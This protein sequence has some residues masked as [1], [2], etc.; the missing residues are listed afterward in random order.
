MTELTVRRTHQPLEIDL[1]PWADPY[2]AQLFVEAGLLVHPGLSES[3]PSARLPTSDRRSQPAA[4]NGG[5]IRSWAIRPNPRRS[6]PRRQRTEAEHLL[7]R[8]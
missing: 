4:A 3:A 2:I 6:T 8:C 5:N 7:A 1:L